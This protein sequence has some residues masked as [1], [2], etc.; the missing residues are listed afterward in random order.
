MTDDERNDELAEE[1]IEDLEAPAW[2]QDVAGGANTCATP[3][4]VGGSK[5]KTYCEPPTCTFTM[6]NCYDN[7]RTLVVYAH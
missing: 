5:V 6:Q 2:T 7:T 4:C 3:T 1:T